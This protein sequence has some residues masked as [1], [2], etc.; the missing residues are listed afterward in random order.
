MDG[1]VPGQSRQVCMTWARRG[2][3]TENVS[4]LGRCPGWAPCW[5]TGE[6]GRKGA[7]R[8][9]P[10]RGLGHEGAAFQGD[11]GECSE[12]CNVSSG[13]NKGLRA[14]VLVAVWA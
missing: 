11:N 3:S 2:E 13:H 1:M 4:D 12:R 6:E 14:L 7:E 8:S 9:G 10:R 5:R